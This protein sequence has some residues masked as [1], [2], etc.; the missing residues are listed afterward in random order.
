M[1]T[2]GNLI[3]KLSITNIRMWFLEDIKRDSNDDHAIAEATKKTNIVNQQ[4]TDL[5]QEIDEFMLGLL[6]GSITMKNYKQGEL[7]KYGS[8]S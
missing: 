4:R 6:D 3:D 1:E 8:D 5:I 7:K 2:L